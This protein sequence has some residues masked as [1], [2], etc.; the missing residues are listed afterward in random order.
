M[1]R[2]AMTAVKDNV[3]KVVTLWLVTYGSWVIN[4]NLQCYKQRVRENPE[5]YNAGRMPVPVDMLYATLAARTNKPFRKWT[6]EERA[7]KEAKWGTAAFKFFYMLLAST[8]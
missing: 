4:G 5:P 1:A 3:C 2:D 8:G 6:A 7:E